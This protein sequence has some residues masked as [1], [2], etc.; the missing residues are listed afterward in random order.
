MQEL[1]IAFISTLLGGF[2]GYFSS[3]QQW[4]I[5][6]REQAQGQFDQEIKNLIDTS[7][8]CLAY[9]R[10]Y[11]LNS[12]LLSIKELRLQMAGRWPVFKL[13]GLAIH[14]VPALRGHIIAAKDAMLKLEEAPLPVS[15]RLHGQVAEE[16]Y[17]LIGAVSEYR[18]SKDSSEFKPKLF[19]GRVVTKTIP[20]EPTKSR[21]HE[22]VINEISEPKS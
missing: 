5:S 7:H 15:D 21:D 3:L 11:W 22:V 2:I 10:E 19:G 12:H 4:R 20:F 14:T 9:A 17:N 13:I 1:A 6:A 18:N 8:E 16:L